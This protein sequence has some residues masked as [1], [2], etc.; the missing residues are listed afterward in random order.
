[1]ELKLV[2][3]QAAAVIAAAAT[4]TARTALLI[5]GLL[6]ETGSRV[7]VRGVK[8]PRGRGALVA[9]LALLVWARG[10]R[11]GD[12]ELAPFAGVQFAGSVYSPV[13][14]GR[15]SIGNG[16]DYGATLDARVAP[17]WS[18]EL[19]YSRQETELGSPGV[20]ARY[21]LKIERFM[22]GI[23]EEK[24]EDRARF[25]GVFL[26]GLS[27]FVPGFGGYG[28]DERF[29]LGL[30]LGVKSQLSPRFGLRAEAR[31]YF[32]V[33]ESGAG[34]ACVNGRCLFVYSASGLW[35]GDV[36]AGVFVAF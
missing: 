31:G 3:A 8:A 15:F 10:A 26:L 16:L 29:T 9:F 21:D 20:A 4:A 34:T 14:G 6:S 13:Y 22:A 33:V 7:N 5:G 24:G 27:R 11:A 35:Q 17:S 30:S 18:V 23:Q 2:L 19:L 32:V 36:S 25:F 1:V 28:A 12:F